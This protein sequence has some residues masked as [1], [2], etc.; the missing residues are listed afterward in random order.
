MK[1]KS[2]K[3]ELTTDDL[4]SLL[5][6]ATY[7]R[8]DFQVYL[9]DMF[10]REGKCLEDGWVSVLINDGYLTVIDM[11]SDVNVNKWKPTK[12]SRAVEAVRF[13]EDSDIGYLKYHLTLKDIYNAVQT[14]EGYNY[15][16]ELLSGEGDYYTAY[17]IL[18]LALF[19]EVIYG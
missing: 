4:V 6:D 12:K 9:D 17:N 10:V 11:N 16:R 8:S 5:A 3:V 14:E 2:I 18:Q 1:V 13:D 19:K 15:M 7:G